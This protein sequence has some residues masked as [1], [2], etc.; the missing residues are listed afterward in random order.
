MVSI[1]LLLLGACAYADRLNA[2]AGKVGLLMRSVSRLLLQMDMMLSLS[3]PFTPKF[4]NFSYL[5]PHSS[6]LH[7]QSVLEAPCVL[8]LSFFYYYFQRFTTP[9]PLLCFP[10]IFQMILKQNGRSH[11]SLLSSWNTLK[12][13]LSTWYAQ[14]CTKQYHFLFD[15][16]MLILCSVHTTHVFFFFFQPSALALAF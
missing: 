11:W 14:I 15:A 13:M 1:Q 12:L 6:M 10:G 7:C 8:V 5:F 3:W 9:Y 4:Y 2:Q 16:N